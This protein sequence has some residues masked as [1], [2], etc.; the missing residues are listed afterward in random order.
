MKL[1]NIQGASLGQHPAQL[2]YNFLGSFIHGRVVQDG[3]IGK[4][5]C[6]KGTEV[7]SWLC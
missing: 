5:Y 6:R 4:V 7:V 2:Y 1:I 3:D